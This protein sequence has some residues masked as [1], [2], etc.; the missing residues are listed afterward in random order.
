MTDNMY[1]GNETLMV[2]RDGDKLLSIY[3]Q[4]QPQIVGYTAEAYNSLKNEM[5]E[6]VSLL[7][8]Y[9]NILVENGLLEEEKTPEQQ[10]AEINSKF[11]KML[12]MIGVFDE[13]LRKVEVAHEH[14]EN[15]SGSRK[16]DRSKSEP[17]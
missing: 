3:P 9:K 2:R 16:V 10:L 5:D 1:M 15:P 4:N 12:D 6:A 7:D 14:T 11:D 17:T 8:S 13:R